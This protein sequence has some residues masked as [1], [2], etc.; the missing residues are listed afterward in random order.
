MRES[1]ILL[2]VKGFTKHIPSFSGKQM[3]LTAGR[4]WGPEQGR[5]YVRPTT[6]A[7]GVTVSSQHPCPRVH[8]FTLI[9]LLVVLAVI[10][11]LMSI[12]APA[13]GRAR[14][15]GRRTVCG[16]NLRE[17]GQ[18]FWHYSNDYEGWFPAKPWCGHDGAGVKDLALHQQDACMTHSSPDDPQFFAV[19]FAGTIRDITEHEYTHGSAEAPKYFF[20]P[21][22][23]VCPSDSV[24][25]VYNGPT[26]VPIRGVD[27]VRKI[28]PLTSARQQKEKN[29]S[30]AYIS[31]LRNDD[32]ADIFLMGDESNQD[33]VAVDYLTQADTEDNH[34]RRGINALFVDLHV[35]WGPARGGDRDSMQQ[36]ARKLFAPVC[37]APARFPPSNGTRN[38][39]IQTID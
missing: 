12:L 13:L 3:F 34:G 23:L 20:N 1:A 15:A 5:G 21:K 33:D 14:E 29:Y 26:L 27:D 8:A 2:L 19:S 36:L 9:E 18:S 22:V 7:E 16:T 4:N 37:A 6:A 31:L 11:L 17:I 24:G 28:E 38:S 39:E 10:A 30:Y 32:R 35:E 25:N